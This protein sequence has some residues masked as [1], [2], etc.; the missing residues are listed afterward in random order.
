MKRFRID[1]AVREADVP[2]EDAK[3]ISFGDE[4]PIEG[5]FD[6]FNRCRD[7]ALVLFT[8]R[9][10]A[11]QVDKEKEHMQAEIDRLKAT[12]DLERLKHRQ[13]MAPDPGIMR[14]TRPELAPWDN[15]PSKRWRPGMD[16]G[17]RGGEGPMS[18]EAQKYYDDLK[19]NPFGR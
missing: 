10:P 8:G 3:G 11:V 4:V 12:I 17:S 19:N 15:R 6:F 18:P 1:F 16:D 5:L 14:P 2:P 9:S 13:A 7:A